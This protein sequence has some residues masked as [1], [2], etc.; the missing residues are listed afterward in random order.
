[1]RK[2][3]T[4]MKKQSLLK[5]GCLAQNSK[6]SGKRCKEWR[7]QSFLCDR[8]SFW[9]LFLWWWKLVNAS[10]HLVTNS[11]Q[12]TGCEEMGKYHKFVWNVRNCLW[13]QFTQAV[14]IY[15]FLCGGKKTHLG[16]HWSLWKTFSKSW[17]CW[18]WSHGITESFMLFIQ[19]FPLFLF[20]NGMSI[21]TKSSV[22]PL[23]TNHP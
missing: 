2:E 14:S 7:E 9:V 15:S 22:F 4:S 5:L 16:E 8:C 10:L 6:H 13:G 20:S 19:V 3:A 18:F 23:G 21:N 1:M 12:P 11:G 17:Q